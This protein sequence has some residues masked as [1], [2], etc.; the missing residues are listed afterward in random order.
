MKYG[1]FIITCDCC[2]SDSIRIWERCRG[3]E[4]THV[5]CCDSCKNEVEL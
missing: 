4:Y 2:G 5:I 1:G 3:E